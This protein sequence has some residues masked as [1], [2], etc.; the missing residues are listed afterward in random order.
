MWQIGRHLQPRARTHIIQT[1]YFIFIFFFSSLII[2]FI[3]FSGI[4]ACP[5]MSVIHYLWEK[6]KRIKCIDKSEWHRVACK[7]AAQTSVDH[8]QIEIALANTRW[9]PVAVCDVPPLT[10]T[11]AIQLLCQLNWRDRK[12]TMES[13]RDGNEGDMDTGAARWEM[14]AIY[15]SLFGLLAKL[16]A[17]KFLCA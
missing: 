5:F 8:K 16:S 3:C 12:T 13:K 17:I 15:R 6:Q 14:C 9:A 2:L 4:S 1:A 7:R 10:H 11:F